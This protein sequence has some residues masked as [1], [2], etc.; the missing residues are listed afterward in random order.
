M[1]KREILKRDRVNRTLESIFDYPLTV[2]EAPIG[3][4]KTTAVREFLISK[5]C[6]VM[7]ISFLSSEDTATY[8]WYRLSSEIGRLDSET[9]DSLK[10]SDF[11]PMHLRRRM[12]FLC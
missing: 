5:G 6:P 12:F 3:Y 1:K 8:F 7:W 2:V 11:P 10:A 9:S 4:G